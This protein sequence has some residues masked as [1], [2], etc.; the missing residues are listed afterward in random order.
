MTAAIGEP[1]AAGII[2]SLFNKY[3]LNGRWRFQCC[4]APEE[5]PDREELRSNSSGSCPSSEAG[6]INAD[7]SYNHVHVGGG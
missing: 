3:I 4:C 1:I 2:V 5:T 7:L 6:A